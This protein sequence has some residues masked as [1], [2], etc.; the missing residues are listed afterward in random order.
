MSD[1]RANPPPDGRSVTPAGAL[2]MNALAGWGR[3]ITFALLLLLLT[4]YMIRTLGTHSYGVWALV[5]AVVGVLELLDMGLTTA[6]VRLVAELKGSGDR[7][8][9]SRVLSTVLALYLG[10]AVLAAA[11]LVGATLGIGALFDLPASD[12][13]NAQVALVLL[14]GRSVLGLPLNLYR[15]ALHGN[16]LVRYSDAIRVG[17][18][19]IYGI[20]AWIGLAAGLGIVGLAAATLSSSIVSWF[21]TARLT[22]RLLPELRIGLGQLSMQEARRTL[23]ISV[24]FA[25]GNL[26]TLISTRVDAFVLQWLVGLHAV[27]IYSIAARLADNLLLLTKQFIHALSPGAAERA[28][29][30]DIAGLQLVALQGTKYALAITLP[31]VVPLLIFAEPLLMTWIGPDFAASHVPL[32]ILVVWVAI[33]VVNL[34]ASGVLAMTGHHRFDAVIAACGAAAN[35][36]ITV[37][38]VLW[39]GLRG[40]AWGTLIASGSVGLC[41]LVPR[42]LSRLSLP[43]GRFL[44][45]A[46]LPAIWPIAPS[47]AL[48]WTLMKLAPP[49]TLLLVAIYGLSVATI[50]VVVFFVIGTS[51]QEKQFVAKR[52]RRRRPRSR[53]R[54]A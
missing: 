17:T 40:A 23:R 7:S 27:A 39:L 10:L 4:P 12:R 2:A 42:M 20:L 47:A 3:H 8:R 15:A 37:P 29:A 9:M 21:L 6:T 52:L 38:L 53:S 30:G 45:Q 36:L 24:A 19:A 22:R 5:V 1:S 43:P 26:T 33:S 51:A 13:W 25:V 46:I 32:Q 35:L 14:G 44:R 54:A 49:G 11:A 50:H 16:G 34:Q 31:V 41:A 48:G 28:G 18:L